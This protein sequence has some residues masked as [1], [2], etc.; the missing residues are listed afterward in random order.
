[1]LAANVHAGS[2][3]TKPA[4]RK[5][6]NFIPPEMAAQISSNEGSFARGSFMRPALRAGFISSHQQ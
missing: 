2:A 4:A 1:L 5:I 6:D 3:K